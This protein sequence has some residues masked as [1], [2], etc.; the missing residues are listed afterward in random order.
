MTEEEQHSV[1]LVHDK[2][3]IASF[4]LKPM[5]SALNGDGM[6]KLK[7]HMEVLLQQSKAMEVAGFSTRPD[8]PLKKFDLEI[9]VTSEEING[10]D[11]QLQLESAIRQSFTK[12]DAHVDRLDIYLNEAVYLDKAF[13]VNDSRAILSLLAHFSD[14]TEL[15]RLW[16]FRIENP[17]GSEFI[18]AGVPQ[19]RR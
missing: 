16:D 12:M 15:F 19:N 5:S 14:F 1:R 9:C 3:R 13:L 18:Y 11:K 7:E 10:P 2:D 17:V 4:L 6:E 8:R